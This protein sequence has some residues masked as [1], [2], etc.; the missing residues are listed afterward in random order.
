MGKGIGNMFGLGKI[1]DPL[2]DSIGLG[3]LKPIVSLAF[4]FATGNVLGLMGD[5][6]ELVNSFADGSFLENVASRPPLPSLFDSNSNVNES[7]YDDYRAQDDYSPSSARPQSSCC[8]DN[9]LSSGRI[10]DFF[11]ALS[12]IFSSTDPADMLQKLGNLFDVLRDFT[13]NQETVQAARNNMQF[14]ISGDIAYDRV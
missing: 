6:G 2:L 14:Q 8:G 3:F 12:G 10:G 4:N 11:R 1:F 13:E 7:D 9:D 5:L